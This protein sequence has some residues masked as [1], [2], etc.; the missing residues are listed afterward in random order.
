VCRTGRLATVPGYDHPT[1]FL[2]DAKHF[3]AVDK[4]AFTGILGVAA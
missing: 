3:S 1:D 4:S 2:P